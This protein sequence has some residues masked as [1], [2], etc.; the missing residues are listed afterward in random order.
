MGILSILQTLKSKPLIEG[1][2][3]II[4]RPCSFSKNIDILAIVLCV[5]FYIL[6]FMVV[7]PNAALLPGSDISRHFN[8]SSILSR[9]PDLYGGGAVYVLFHAFEAAV[10]VM[11]GIQQSVA[12][13][14]TVLVVLNV[15]LPISI[16]LLAKRFLSDI[17]KRIPA[18]SVL[19]YTILS[20][21]SFIYYTQLK[22]LGTAGAQIVN[23]VAE[24]SQNGNIN[25]LQPFP[26]FVPL[27]VSIILFVMAFLLLRE[28]KI[29]RA[30]FVLLFSTIILSM[31]LTHVAEAV[32]FTIFLGLYSFISRSKS[33]RID[34]A[35]VS[36]LIGLVIV[37]YFCWFYISMDS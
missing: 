4:E 1:Q 26:F 11:S 3:V 10:L 33:L 23:Q 6:F 8:L 19:F 5:A 31:Y 34:D 29:P 2:P 16:Y 37:S 22:I 28:I 9:S 35:L 30:K 15:F 12:Q 27:S 36:S 7:Y 13:V 17:D 18:I 20:N 14:Q 32:V 24:R 25:P 21:F